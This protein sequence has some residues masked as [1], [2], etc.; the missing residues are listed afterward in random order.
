MTVR[1]AYLAA[2][3]EVLPDIVPADLPDGWFDALAA[4]NL[5]TCPNLVRL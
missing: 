5:R 4:E 1:E 3:P 2:L